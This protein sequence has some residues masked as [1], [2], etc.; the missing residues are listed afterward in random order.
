[1]KL[2]SNRCK[3]HQ[4]N[5]FKKMLKFQLYSQLYSLSKQI[6]KCDG[7]GVLTVNC[8]SLHKPLR[9]P[10]LYIE[11]KQD[12]DGLLI[13]TLNLSNIQIKPYNNT[14]NSNFL[15]S[16]LSKKECVSFGFSPFTIFS[17]KGSKTTD[18]KKIKINVYSCHQTVP[19]VIFY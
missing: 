8:I 12:N 19:S 3:R 4:V 16:T 9:V 18:R 10:F 17:T 7:Q 6:T 13:L 14:Y 11:E 2:T 1:M 15:V 5:R